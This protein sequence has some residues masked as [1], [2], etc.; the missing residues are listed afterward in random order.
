[1]SLPSAANWDEREKTSYFQ[2]QKKGFEMQPEKLSLKLDFLPY[3]VNSTDY[4]RQEKLL[5]FFFTL[6]CFFSW[7]EKHSNQNFASGELSPLWSWWSPLQRL[8]IRVHCVG[9]HMHSFSSQDAVF[10]LYLWKKKKSV[11][12]AQEFPGSIFSFFS[13][14]CRTRTTTWCS[15]SA[16]KVGSAKLSVQPAP[17]IST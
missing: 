2:S 9:P 6:F 3:P 8:L 14:V 5:F 10:I 13:C 12:A 7:R 16:L 15:W 4:W 11:W 1:M 17:K